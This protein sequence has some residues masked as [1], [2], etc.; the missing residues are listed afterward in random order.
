MAAVQRVRVAT[1]AAHKFLSSSK[2]P[3]FARILPSDAAFT[4]A[5]NNG[6]IKCNKE[7]T[8]AVLKAV[9]HTTHNIHHAGDK[10]RVSA[11][12]DICKSHN[13]LPSNFTALATLL[14]QVPNT[15]TVRTDL[16]SIAESLNDPGAILKS[17]SSILPVIRSTLVLEASHTWRKL[18][19]LAAD[20]KVPEAYEQMAETC[21]RLKNLTQAQ[22]YWNK[23]AELDSGKAC[24][25]LG[26]YALKNGRVELA[27]EWFA[28]GADRDEAEAYYELGVLQMEQGK[29]KEDAEHNL[30]V[31]AASGVGPAAAKLE[32][33]YKARN[34][35]AKG[36]RWGELAGEMEKVSKN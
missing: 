19:A 25:M 16:L 26:R 30:L 28:K 21:E 29:D 5:V 32:Q 23:A 27:M 33:L 24:L 8:T 14:Q 22:H 15:S 13:F 1:S 12:S 9:W 35:T 36:A 10:A 17:A 6:F 31:A 3:D 20:H 18:A 2:L 34:E 4:S 7:E 11:L